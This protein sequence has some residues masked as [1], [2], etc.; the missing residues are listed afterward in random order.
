MTIRKP[1]SAQKF[2]ST[3][4]ERLA[5]VYGDSTYLE[6]GKNK[7]LFDVSNCLQFRLDKAR[8][9][10]NNK[11][12]SFI[13]CLSFDDMSPC[14]INHDS[15][16][17]DFKYFE[18]DIY[19]AVD[20]LDSYII[21]KLGK[22]R[23]SAICADYSILKWALLPMFMS[24]TTNEELVKETQQKILELLAAEI[25]DETSVDK[26]SKQD[27]KFARIFSFLARDVNTDEVDTLI[28]FY[29]NNSQLN[30]Y[31]V[32]LVN[33]KIS[34]NDKDL[35]YYEYIQ[36]DYPEITL[37]TA[38]KKLFREHYDFKLSNAKFQLTHTGKENGNEEEEELTEELLQELIRNEL[39]V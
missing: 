13:E 26:N 1:V 17:T 8:E 24:D 23:D 16:L 25:T 38:I 9:K 2:I 20:T 32:K 30:V 11:R 35:L 6:V 33:G 31:K 39:E 14:V 7:I 19:N 3:V 28:L 21:Q 12:Q 5:P 15:T 10:T 29:P 27:K 36:D 4:Q 37:T 34:D 22:T 18:R